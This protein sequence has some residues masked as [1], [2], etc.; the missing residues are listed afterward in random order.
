MLSNTVDIIYIYGWVWFIFTASQLVY[1]VLCLIIFIHIYVKYMNWFVWELWHINHGR[2]FNAVTSRT[3]SAWRILGILKKLVGR[4]ESCFGRKRL[5]FACSRR[6]C[7]RCARDGGG[8]WKSQNRKNVY[9][10]PYGGARGVIVI[11]TGYGHSD[12][13]SI[14]G[15][16]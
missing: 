5:T 10:S 1:V 12:T 15:Q 3:G 16:N 11:V 14:P 4:V 2:L 6:P 8:R 13:S 7:D 9:L